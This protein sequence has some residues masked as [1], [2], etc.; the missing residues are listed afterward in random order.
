MS[1]ICPTCNIPVGPR[2]RFCP[3]CG[4]NLPPLVETASSE[5]AQTIATPSPQAETASLASASGKS[6]SVAAPPPAAEIARAESRP[7]PPDPAPA[8]AVAVASSPPF[9]RTR[10][11]FGPEECPLEMAVNFSR[12]LVAGHSTTLEFRIGSREPQPLENIQVNLESRGLS[13][14]VSINLRRL[15]A[16]QQPVKILEVEPA[17]AGNFVL[18]VGA[19]WESAGQQFAY[20]GQR[21]M[22]VLQ[23][24]ESGNIQISIGDI[25]SN[26]GTGANQGLGGD[27]GDVRI[28]NLLGGIKTLNDLLELE[29]PEKFHVI[30][31]ELDYELSRTAIDGQ[32]RR[33]SEALRIPQSLLTTVNPGTVCLFEPADNTEQSLPFRLVARP[34]FRLGRARAEAD[35]I[36]WVLPRNE[37]NDERTMR[38]SKVQVIADTSTGTLVLRDNATANGSVLD[39][40]ILD[41]VGATL[42]RRGKLMLGGAVEIDIARF[43]SGRTGDP[44]IVNERSWNGPGQLV[45]PL[46]G[47]VRCELITT[48]LQPLNSAWL[49]SDAAFGTNRANAVVLEWPE[50][51]EIQGRFHHYRGCFW[52][53]NTTE[54]GLVRIDNLTL[55]PGYIAPLATG[56]LLRLGARTFRMKIGP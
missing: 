4:A 42:E 55:L 49:L 25:Q 26:S 43:D 27:R 28:D 41:G 56:Q 47:A 23:A 6:V 22:R 37:A 32:R 48:D 50:L 38:V 30:P 5:T 3:G 10:A 39:G 52:V 45:P 35:F 33:T 7:A 31:L 18:Q 14:P 2:S 16:G 40:Q 29:L 24:P 8:P 46:R 54:T 20:R 11:P 34:Q 17:R 12:M 53:E 15:A 19:T 36:T 51:A 1:R 44:P 9:R 13:G 21:P